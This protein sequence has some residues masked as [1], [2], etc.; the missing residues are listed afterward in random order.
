MQHSPAN[1][2]LTVSLSSAGGWFFGVRNTSDN[3]RLFAGPSN[4]AF[5]LTEDTAIGAGFADSGS[6]QAAV[7]TD[8][9]FGDG[10][11]HRVVINKSQGTSASDIGIW[12]DGSN[13]SQSIARDQGVADNFSN[14]DVDVPFMAYNSQ[15][16]VTAY[17]DLVM[18]EPII[19]DSV[20]SEQQ[21]QDDYDRQPWS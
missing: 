19:F 14:F 3:T 15:G 18:D 7:E 10:S 2:E 13:V 11:L 20:L 21:I 4:S 5:G 6:N 12:I 17:Q 1:S 9:T 16:S 8:A